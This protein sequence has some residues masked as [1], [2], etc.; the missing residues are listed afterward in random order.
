MKTHPTPLAY[1]AL[2]L[3]FTTLPGIA[4]AQ[5]SAPSLKELQFLH[6]VQVAAEVTSPYREGVARLNTGYQAGLDRELSAAK[7]SGDLESALALDT[8]IK[9]LANK[10]ALPAADDQ[11]PP[12]LKKLRAIYRA[13]LSKIDALRVAAEA[14][15][16][17]PF[18]AKLREMEVALTKA[19]NLE[20]ATKVMTYRKELAAPSATGSA[21]V[22][23]AL[24]PA[25][26]SQTLPPIGQKNSRVSGRGFPGWEAASLD[27]AQLETI[28]LK[29]FPLEPGLATSWSHSWTTVP[30]KLIQYP[31]TIFHQTKEAAGIAQCNVT[32]DGWLLVGV[33]YQYQGNESGGWTDERWTL[34]QFENNGWAV[35]SEKEAGGLL[36][37][38]NKEKT[39][40]RP[41]TLLAKYVKKGETLRLRCNKY[42]PPFLILLGRKK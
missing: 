11:V 1:S 27:P 10:E 40:A 23:E 28:D 8:E 15:L 14:K 5:Q 37:K 20:E 16:R 9:R 39:S 4:P 33:N 12:T 34:E 29:S 19:G 25:P 30:E 32:E 3:V 18:V 2:L 26:V 22:A 24:S 38:D 42:D 35:V 36:V 7:A 13:E 41:Q 21:P 6:D 17:E 31:A